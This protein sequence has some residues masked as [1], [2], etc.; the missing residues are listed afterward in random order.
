MGSK[1]Q[2]RR[3]E[4]GTGGFYFRPADRSWVGGAHLV[5]QSNGPS[6]SLADTA[7]RPTL[8]A[9]NGRHV[10]LRRRERDQGPAGRPRRKPGHRR[11][12]RFGG[13]MQVEGGATKPHFLMG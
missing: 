8:G 6:H 10:K 1:R 13:P 3:D 12:R 2:C 5:H 7:C 9:C 4:G 11:R